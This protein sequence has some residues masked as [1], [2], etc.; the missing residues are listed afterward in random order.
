MAQ[1]LGD[2]LW[3]KNLDLGPAPSDS[4][5]E[6]GGTGEGEGEENESESGGSSSGSGE[7][8]DD[9]GSKGDE[10]GETGEG[11]SEQAG[12]GNDSGESDAEAGKSGED[13]DAEDAEGQKP[14]HQDA[15]DG[16]QG[17][18]GRASSDGIDD[19]NGGSN[20]AGQ[21]AGDGVEDQDLAEQLMSALEAGGETGLKDSSQALG[22]TA[23][24]AGENND[25]SDADPDADEQ[26]WRPYST[27]GDQ[28]YVPRQSA[29]ELATA[30]RYKR[31][32]KAEI[33]ALKAKLRAK[34][35]QARAP[36]VLHGVRKG[37]SLSLRSGNLVN[38]S[39]ETRSGRRPTRPDMRRVHREACTIA[40]AI[41][42][43]QSGSMDKN[44]IKGATQAS[45][46]LSEALDG[47][48]SPVLVCSPRDGGR[49]HSYKSFG[50]RYSRNPEEYRQYHRFD[51]I[52]IDLFKDWDERMVSRTLS[53]FGGIT[54]TGSTPLSDGIQFAL[55]E[56]AERDERHRIVFVITDGHPNNSNVVRYQIRKAAEAGVTVVGVG[57]GWGA[58]YVPNL[59]PV[60]VYREE[61]EGVATEVLQ[62][63]NGIVFPKRAK[64]LK[65]SGKRI[66]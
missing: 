60:S 52:T 2:A 66:A 21:G 5:D 54:S 42:I 9:E 56:L 7:S 40:A 63:L 27:D 34:F 64:K 11:S 48:G 1:I 33:S 59:F 3:G 57:I 65:L 35:L 16:E 61:I 50:D 45:I 22:E 28:I 6:S 38:T 25:Q 30:Q 47:V 20:S 18:E 29:K 39:I 32:V 26:A 14:G 23:A 43:D 44:L 55:Q 51:N 13:G 12:D 10:E 37:D 8:E 46:A 41:V 19:D 24:D 49:S 62:V 4:D 53:R 17:E 15:A 31:S 36:Q 58:S